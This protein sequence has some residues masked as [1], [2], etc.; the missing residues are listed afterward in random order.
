MKV[1]RTIPRQGFV[2]VNFRFREGGAFPYKKCNKPGKVDFGFWGSHILINDYRGFI[3]MKSY[4]MVNFP[5]VAW[6]PLV[7]PVN[8]GHKKPLV[9]FFGDVPHLNFHLL[10]KLTP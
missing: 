6:V 9:P 1:C 10:I 4:Y 2:S 8:N 5:S 7:Q 3:D